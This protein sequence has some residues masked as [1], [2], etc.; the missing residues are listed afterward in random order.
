MVALGALA[1]GDVT[2]G[3]VALGA[4]ALGTLT[5]G[6]GGPPPPSGGK[7][8]RQVIGGHIALPQWEVV[9][10]GEGSQWVAKL[11]EGAHRALQA[12]A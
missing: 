4:L 2:F 9:G 3:A 12:S 5:L 8:T 6:A 7:E 10:T 11:G 1:V